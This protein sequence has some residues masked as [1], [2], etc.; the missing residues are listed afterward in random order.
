MI[1][2]VL[3]VVAAVLRSAFLPV[4]LARVQAQEPNLWVVLDL[5]PLVRRQ[6]GSVKPQRLCLNNLNPIKHLVGMLRRRSANNFS[7]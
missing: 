7:R 6:A 1:A 5:Q 4:N 2:A 3:V